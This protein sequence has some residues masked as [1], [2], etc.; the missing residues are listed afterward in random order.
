MYSSLY[1]LLMRHRGNEVARLTGY[2][3]EQTHLR[4]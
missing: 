1:I 4:S 2:D 3:V